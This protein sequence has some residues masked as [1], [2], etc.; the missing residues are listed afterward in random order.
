MPVRIFANKAAVACLGVSS[1][2]ALVFIAYDYFLP[3][4]FQS[5]LGLAPT[6]SG[7]LLFALVI[8]LSITSTATGFFVKKTG[9]SRSA[10]WFGLAVM[11][12]GT[13]LFIAFDAHIVWAKVIVFQI[14]AGTGAGPLFQSP[15]IA[16]QTHLSPGDV[17]PG[18]SGMTFLRSL[19]TSISIVLGGVILQQGL[20][21]ETFLTH[22]TADGGDSELNNATYMCALKNIWI[23]YT[24]LCGVGVLI[25]LFVPGRLEEKKSSGRGVEKTSES[26][27]MRHDD[28]TGDGIGV[29]SSS[30]QNSKA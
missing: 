28:K 29:D 6:T 18:T 26:N 9:S 21:S 16:L 3:L 27:E 7:L 2:H 22:S 5:V 23:F 11:P 8:P 25:S 20:G 15:L 10:I 17:A 24:V 1:C 13:G 12:V 19:C 14:V 30:N 4:Y